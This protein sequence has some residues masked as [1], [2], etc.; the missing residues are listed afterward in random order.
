M[1]YNDIVEDLTAQQSQQDKWMPDIEQS[2][3]K[4]RKKKTRIK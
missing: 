1:K 3:K 4:Q 2:I